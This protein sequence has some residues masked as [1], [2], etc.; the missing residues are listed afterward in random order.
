MYFDSNILFLKLTGFW[1]YDN[2]NET[3]V[4]KK[5]LQHSYNIFWFC[6]LFIAYLPAEIRYLYYC[7]D[8]LNEFLRAL[9]DIGNHVSLG[10]KAV[11]FFRMRKELLSVIDVLQN[12]DYNYEVCEKFNPLEIIER[13]KKQALK[14]TKYFLNFCNAICLSMFLNGL[15]TFIFMSESQYHI[16]NDVKVYKQQQP[17]NTVSPFGSGTKWQF[18]VT[19]IYTMIALTFYAWMIVGKYLIIIHD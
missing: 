17:V 18:F 7:F 13:E 3:K 11:N 5:Y 8:N 19:F 4:S 16:E 15:F 14:W 12:G 6:Y 10:Y 2:P 9:R 1:V